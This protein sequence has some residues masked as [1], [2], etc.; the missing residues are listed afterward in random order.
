MTELV[1]RLSIAVTMIAF[2]IEQVGWPRRWLE[3]L[4]PQ[5]AAV[6][7]LK[8]TM[9]MRLHGT[10]NMIL[11]VWFLLGIGFLV[12]SWLTLLWWVSILPFA[13]YRNWRIGLRDVAITAGILM[14]AV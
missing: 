4:P 5:L 14:L 12:S 1:L 13:F 7:P 3:Y 8:E 9:V 6:I 10:I 2:G 11:G